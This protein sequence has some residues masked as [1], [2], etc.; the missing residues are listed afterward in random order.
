MAF[1]DLTYFTTYLVLLEDFT[2][3]ADFCRHSKEERPLQLEQQ[4][5]LNRF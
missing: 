1:F 4:G 5:K 2:E 3:Y